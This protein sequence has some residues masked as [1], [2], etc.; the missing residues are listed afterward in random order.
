[1]QKLLSSVWVKEEEGGGVG[2]GSHK[3]T[4]GQLGSLDLLVVYL[5]IVM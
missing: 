5:I 3:C 2:V 4:S 1:M